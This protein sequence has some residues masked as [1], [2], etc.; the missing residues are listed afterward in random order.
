MGAAAAMAVNPLLLSL[1][2]ISRRRR[3]SLGS[4]GVA[5]R[6]RL[7]QLKILKQF[8]SSLPEKVSGQ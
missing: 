1:V 3:R 5:L 2:T 8:L 7:R 4:D 6:K